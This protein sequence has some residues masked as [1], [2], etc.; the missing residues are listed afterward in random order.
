MYI[1]KYS[2][3]S[4][5]CILY[6][7]FQKVR[8]LCI[9]PLSQFTGTYSQTIKWT[10]GRRFSDHVEMN[11]VSIMKIVLGANEICATFPH[12][13][14]ISQACSNSAVIEGQSEMSYC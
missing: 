5:S 14:V 13:S 8:Q 6:E 12:L 4:L 1:C 9:Q 10:I 11:A 3:C 2:K 7:A